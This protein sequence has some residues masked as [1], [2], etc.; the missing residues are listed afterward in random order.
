MPVVFHSRN[1][2]LV[3]TA[4]G[5]N[6]VVQEPIEVVRD[7]GA[8]FQV[9]VGATSDGASTPAFMWP[10]L[11]P[12]GL[13]WLAAVVHDAAYRGTLLRLTTDNEWKLAMLPKDECD[14]L[15]LDCMSALGVDQ[16][17]KDALY[18]GV[19]LLGWGSFKEDRDGVNNQGST[20]I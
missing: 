6:F 18:E 14:T 2:V 20:T 1:D 13:W 3:R 12:F 7:D 16:K 11:A 5:R 9:P 4:D 15:F 19:H 17:D 10:K 8:R